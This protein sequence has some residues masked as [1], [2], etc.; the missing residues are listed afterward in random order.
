M[1]HWV[2]L[3]LALGLALWAKYFVVVLAVP[4]ALFLMLDHEARSELSPRPAPMS[5]SR[6]RSSSRPRISPGWWQTISCPS[7]MPMRARRRRA[8]SS[9]TSVHP[10]QFLASQL[11]FIAPALLIAAPLVWP[12][13]AEP[14]EPAGDGYDRRIVTLLA[15]GPAATTFALSLL[16]GRG[17]I[18]MWGYPLWLFLGLWI[19]MMAAAGSRASG[20]RR[21]RRSGPSCSAALPPPSP[22]A[23]PCMPR[24][25]GR[26][27]AVFYPGGAL[28]AE[29][30]Q[31]FR[32]VTGRPLAYVIGDMWTGGNVAH[33]APGRPRNLIDGNPRRAPWIDM[34]DLRSRG[35]VVVWTGGDPT[36]IPAGLRAVAGEAEVQPP[37]ALP[38][39]WGGHTL[40]VGWAILKP[41]SA[42]AV[43][44]VARLNGSD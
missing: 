30:S 37:F 34:S 10:L 2:L 6:S 3:G 32:A 1:L 23:T 19:V 33:Y 14:A 17:V 12:R 15:F 36:T 9:T 13:A 27:R 31:R 28:G 7:P 39:R 24:Y 8:G 22:R 26:Y 42:F 25:D 43:S 4:L 35:A 41:R 18:A 40:P 16:T 29:L 21:S 5:R 11:V 44:G 38:F 20:S